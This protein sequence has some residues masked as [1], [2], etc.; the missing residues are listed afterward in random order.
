MF[1]MTLTASQLNTLR[2]TFGG[3]S[4]DNFIVLQAFFVSHSQLIVG[5]VSIWTERKGNE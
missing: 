1:L 2:A 5:S 3:V 4:F